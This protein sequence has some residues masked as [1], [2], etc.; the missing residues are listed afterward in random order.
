MVSKDPSK[1]LPSKNRACIFLVVSTSPASTKISSGNTLLMRQLGLAP[2]SQVVTLLVM[3]MKTNT[4]PS[5]PL[6]CHPTCMEES[7]KSSPADSTT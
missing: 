7:L 4:S 6:W 5:T 2:W 3:S 1:L